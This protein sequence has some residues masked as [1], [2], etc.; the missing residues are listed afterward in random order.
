M[1]P[2][3]LAW[4]FV[5]IL[6][7][8]SLAYFEVVS[9]CYWH[10]MFNFSPPA[11]LSFLLVC[12]FS[13]CCAKYRNSA[14]LMWLQELVLQAPELGASWT[15]WSLH[16]RCWPVGD[17]KSGHPAGHTA[18]VIGLSDGSLGAA[19]EQE[20]YWNRFCIHRECHGN[21]VLT[22][23]SISSLC[24]SCCNTGAGLVLRP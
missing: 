11:I 8:K 3:S 1:L 21:T 18:Y 23:G 19:G 16:Y 22:I 14:S 7:G 6:Y 5:H 24:L 15:G 2:C 12:F 13:I 20:I 17:I 9:L 4:V 10:L